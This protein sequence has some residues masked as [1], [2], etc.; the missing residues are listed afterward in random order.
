[1]KAGNPMAPARLALPCQGIGIC[2]PYA[3]MDPDWIPAGPNDWDGDGFSNKDEYLKWKRK[4]TDSNDLPYD[5]TVIN[6]GA[7]CP[8]TLALEED[9]R[10][11]DLR[12]LRTFRDEVLSKTLVGQEIMRQYY[13][14]GPTIIKAMDEDKEFKAE[15]KEMI[16]GILKLTG[17]AES[18]T[19]VI[20]NLEGSVSALPFPL[21][22]I[23]S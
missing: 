19:D 15:V 22:R 8:A 20:H 6:T 21:L 1:M 17:K 12:I 16:D 4:I 23:A 5:P 10:K 9:S 2:H 18:F 13:T 3:P 11:T 14:W 7:G